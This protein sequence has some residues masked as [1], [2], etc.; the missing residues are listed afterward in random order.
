VEELVDLDGVDVDVAD[1]LMLDDGVVVVGLV[2]V[3]AVVGRDCDKGS[4]G[5]IYARR[6]REP[7][8]RAAEAIR[9]SVPY[10]DDG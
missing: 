10:V 6:N 5:G 8:K 2:T 1:R 4:G 3:E 9:R 7:S